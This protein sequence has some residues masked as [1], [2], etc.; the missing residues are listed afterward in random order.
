MRAELIDPTTDPGWLRLASRADSAT[1]FHH[2]AWIGLLARQYRYTPMAVVLRAAGGDIAAGLPIV[3]VSSAITGTRLVSLPFSDLVPP[4][5]EPGSGD[6]L[7]PP[8]LEA[9]D[10]HRQ[11]LGLRLEVHAPLPGLSSTDRFWHHVVPLEPGFAEVERRFASAQRRGVRKAQRA[12]VV[13]RRSVDRSG[14]D[15]FYRLHVRT[16]RFQGVPT[17]SRRFIRA[18]EGLFRDGLGHV[19]LAQTGERTIAAALFLTWKGT[20]TYKYGASDRDALDQRPNNLLFA[21]AIRR[22]CEDGLRELDM[23]RTDLD[24]PG[25]RAFKLGWGAEEDE[26]VYSKLPPDGAGESVRSMSGL[27]RR[28]IQR[29][30]AAFGRLLGTALY[31]HFA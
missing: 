12:G 26:I 9:V 13:I 6:R 24:N 8:L 23:G 1:A 29:A 4:L 31:R 15:A 19:L 5:Y 27:Q 18:F 25:L 10:Q 3:R 11:R 21:E 22:G 17:Q 28:L 14:L 2:P 20:L 7:E 30:P 16:R